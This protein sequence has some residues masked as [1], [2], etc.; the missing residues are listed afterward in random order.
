MR[1][2]E[3]IGELIEDLKMDNPN[4][5][6]FLKSALT[7][8]GA[9]SP[10]LVDVD[11]LSAKAREAMGLGPSPVVMMKALLATGQ[12]G[13][14]LLKEAKSIGLCDDVANAP[15]V[16]KTILNVRARL[17][18]CLPGQQ[19]YSFVCVRALFRS[20]PRSLAL[21]RVARAPR[22]LRGRAE[23]LSWRARAVCGAP[24]CSRPSCRWA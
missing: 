2:I 5:P 23:A 9:H 10:P 16:L 11:T 8:C 21:R 14:A 7:F 15:A 12:K 19:L 6:K 17:F 3:E 18:F 4:A 13:K 22:V 20:P 24:A 1:A